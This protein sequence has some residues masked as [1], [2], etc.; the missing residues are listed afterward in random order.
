MTSVSGLEARRAAFLIL[1]EQAATGGFLKDSFGPGLPGL[2][3]DDAALARAVCFGVVRLQRLLDYNLDAHAPRG[4]K[5]TKLRMA[6]RVGAYQI[7]FLSG[8]PAFAAVNTTVELVKREVGRAESGFANA[9]LKAVARDGMRVPPGNGF[10][11]LAVRYSHPEWLVRRWGK[12]LKPQALEAALR[13]N[14]EEAPLWVRAN[15]RR[16]RPE[17]LPARLAEEGATIE[18][19]GG[20]PL[21][22]RLVEGA[23]AALRSRAFAAGLFSFQDPVSAWVVSLLDWNPGLS[24]F[25]ACSAPGGKSALALETALWASASRASVRASV[26]EAGAEAV[27]L[28]CG[29]VSVTRLRR[30]DDVRDRLGHAGLMPVCLDVARPPFRGETFD[31]ILVDAPCSNLGVLRRRPEARW[32]WTPERITALAG[33]QRALLDGAAHLLKPGGRL[34]YATCSAEAEETVDVVRAFLAAHPD[35]RVVPAETSVP[36]DLC[37]DGYLRVWPGETDYDGFFAAAITRIG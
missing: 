6:L 33:R 11:S 4:I 7:L 15:P 9:V 16:G 28:V 1:L 34:V 30:L 25:D 2:R 23:G 13:R 19:H 14:N 17:D 26:D 29:D 21:F 8:V 12:E 37:R 18:A 20:L 36:A 27:R 35:F 10:K 3:D 22:F 5:G 32:N 24:L 31:R